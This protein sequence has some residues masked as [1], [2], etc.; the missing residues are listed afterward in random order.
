MTV[1]C[2]Y[3]HANKMGI[4]TSLISQEYYE[5]ERINISEAL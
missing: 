2:L 1:H 3:F 5:L 4:T